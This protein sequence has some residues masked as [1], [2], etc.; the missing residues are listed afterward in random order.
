MKNDAN[1]FFNKL[2]TISLKFLHELSPKRVFSPIIDKC[3][4]SLLKKFSTEN[5]VI[6]SPPDKGKDVVL[7]NRSDYTNSMKNVQLIET[8]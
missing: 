1:E 7:V 2:K 8:V 5:D 6:I 4:I 3:D